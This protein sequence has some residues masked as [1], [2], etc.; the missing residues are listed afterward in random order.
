MYG[1]LTRKYTPKVWPSTFIHDRND[2][3]FEPRS[4]PPPPLRLH[5]SGRRSIGVSNYTVKELQDLL[6]IAQVK[7]AVNQCV[8]PISI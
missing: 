4:P 6:K 5:F 7:P 1:K 3:E 8:A 2:S